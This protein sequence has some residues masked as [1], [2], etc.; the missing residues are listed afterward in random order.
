MLLWTL[1]SIDQ[2]TIDFVL[3]NFCQS[4]NMEFYKNFEIIDCR[5]ER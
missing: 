1:F 3:P 5:F 4:R 2:G